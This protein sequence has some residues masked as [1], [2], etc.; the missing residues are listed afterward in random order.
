MLPKEQRDAA[1]SSPGQSAESYAFVDDAK[2]PPVTL[3]VWGR[4]KV[5]PVNIT[6]MQIREE[7]FNSE[8][9]PTRAIVSVSLQVI[10][11]PNAPFMQQESRN[12]V[13]S[14][15]NENSNNTAKINI[16]KEANF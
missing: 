14:L 11:G 4:K 10:E 12:K 8:L 9:S 16:P 2:N 13:L 6:N 7:E 15:V 3:F 1:G 5:L